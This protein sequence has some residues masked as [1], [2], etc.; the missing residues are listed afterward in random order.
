MKSQSKVIRMPKL[1][2]DTEPVDVWFEEGVILFYDPHY[3]D[4]IIRCSIADFEA[5]VRGLSEL[6]ERYERKHRHNPDARI[7]FCGKMEWE[8]FLYNVRDLIQEAKR[9]IHVGL[10]LNVIADAVASS[11]CL[12]VSPGFE[13]RTEAS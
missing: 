6:V 11:A 8:R 4:Q 12:S 9:Q 1:T 2:P 7:V 3:P 10:P 5:R 13:G